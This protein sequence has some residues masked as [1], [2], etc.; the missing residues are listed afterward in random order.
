M[1]ICKNC[2]EQVDDK[3]KFCPYCASALANVCPNCGEEVDEK[4]KFC[5]YCASPIDGVKSAVSVGKNTASTQPVTPQNDN[6][7][8]F[9]DMEADFDAQLKAREE[10]DKKITLA[11]SYAIRE[12]FDEAR[13]IYDE[14]IEKDPMDMN[15]YI[16]LIRV[17]TKN[18]TVFEG[19]NIDK[20]I[21]VAKQIASVEDLSGFDADFAAYEEN[22]K[23]YFAQKEAARI[24]EEERKAEEARKI[25]FKMIAAMNSHMVGLKLDGTVLAVGDNYYWQCNVSEWRDIVAVEAGCYHTVGLKKD[26]TVVAVG[27]NGKGECNVS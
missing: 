13:A 26:G 16:G 4:F 22:R 3:F 27:M 1:K 14:V 17:E 18:Y 12:R 24:A 8:N 5:P 20:A 6:L 7:F 2:G 23:E 15:G 11:R 19:I 21:R 25:H 9:G 10:Y